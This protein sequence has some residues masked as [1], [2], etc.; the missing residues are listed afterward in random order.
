MK[1]LGNRH[2]LLILCQLANGERSVGELAETLEIAQS[3]LSQHLARMRREGL[4]VTRR[5][6]QTIY[7]SLQGNEVER[8]IQCLYDIYCTD[9][10]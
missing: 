1:T 3:A 2:R 8:V 9:Q 6:G 7:Y 4:V 10:E 5:E